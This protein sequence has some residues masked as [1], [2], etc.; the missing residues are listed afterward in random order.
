MRGSRSNR[1]ETA[2]VVERKPP[3][4]D[5]TARGVTAAALDDVYDEGGN[6]DPGVATK[7]LSSDDSI[8]GSG[9]GPA[10]V[11]QC[12]LRGRVLQ[13]YLAA[14]RRDFRGGNWRYRVSNA[15]TATA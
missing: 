5:Y 10:G 7:R 9:C 12:L 3:V 8:S 15:A 2:I 13:A 14:L 6:E 11:L 1:I 4:T